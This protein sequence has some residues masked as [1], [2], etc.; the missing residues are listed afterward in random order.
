MNW[1]PQATAEPPRRPRP[2]APAPTFLAT[3]ALAICALPLAAGNDGSRNAAATTTG[4][5][6]A[7]AMPLAPYQAEYEVLRKDRPV[8]SSDTRLQRD[9]DAWRLESH[10]RGERGMA[11]LAGFEAR[12]ELRFDWHRGQ[13]RP[14]HSVYDQKATLSSRRIE[15]V[16]DWEQGRYQLSDRRGR[17][18]HALPAG[19]ADRY[20]SQVTLAAR[21]AAGER[22]FSFAVPYPDGLRQWRF[23]VTGEETVTVPAGTFSTLRVERVREDS[24]RQTVSWH[25]PQLD[26]LAVRTLQAEDGTRTESRL[27]RITRAEQSRQPDAGPAASP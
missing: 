16:Y 20:G 9:G 10:T 11:S 13:V 23:R 27:R 15:V 19:T 12:Q 7:A 25:A 3:L 6:T 17:H 1:F 18:S 24:D 2:A 14:L 22:D 4:D 5:S 26:W 21:L 8:G